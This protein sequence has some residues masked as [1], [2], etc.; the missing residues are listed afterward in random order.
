MS[1]TIIDIAADL[2]EEVEN[3]YAL[4]LQVSDIAKRLLEDQRVKYQHD[5]FAMEI[6]S[7]S[8]KVIYQALIMKASEVDMGDGLIG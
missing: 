8:E 5:P 3:R 4:V 2:N 1:S 6:A 7:G